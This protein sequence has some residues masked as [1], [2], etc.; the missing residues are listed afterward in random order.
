MNRAG[1]EQRVLNNILRVPL[2]VR[3][4]MDEVRLAHRERPRIADGFGAPVSR[5]VST[6]TALLAAAI[7]GLV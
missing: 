1:K 7:L 2:L 4:P 5:S 6:R 3:R